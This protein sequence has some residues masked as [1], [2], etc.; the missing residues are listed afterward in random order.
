MN[1]GFLR[2][3][4]VGIL[5]GHSPE[6]CYRT[7]EA[8][9]AGGLTTVEVTMN[10]PA[11]A[12]T[13]TGLQLRFPGVN[14][15]AGTVCTEA[16]LR[17]AVRAGASFIVTPVLNEPVVADCVKRGL[18]VFPGA[19]TPT[20]IYRAWSL[21]A[22][23][24]KVFPAGGLGP[25][26]LRDVAGP[27]PQIKLLP[28]GGVTRANVADFFAAGAYGVGMGSSLVDRALVTAG[29]WAG[30]TA[31]CRAVVAATGYPRTSTAR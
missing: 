30:L 15:G 20:E 11:A 5:R 22:T 14:V 17:T 29:D 10:S 12:D 16:E 27:L 1:E 7:V 13:I 26:Y 4:I 31:H 21:G 23:A 3:P 6:I 9:A 25:G 18:P 19:F 24:V 2:T 28:T 8:L